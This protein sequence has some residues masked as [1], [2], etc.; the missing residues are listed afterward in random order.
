MRRVVLVLLALVLL[1]ACGTTAKSVGEDHDQTW[2]RIDAAPPT[3]T[4]GTVGYRLANGRIMWVNEATGVGHIYAEADEV[5]ADQWSCA[6][7][8]GNLHD[9]YD[10]NESIPNF[11]GVVCHPHGGGT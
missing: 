11:R 4:D 5:N 2:Q 8:I 3:Y 1:A 6:A 9:F 7:L 10:A